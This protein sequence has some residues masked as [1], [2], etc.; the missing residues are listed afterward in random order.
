MLVERVEVGCAGV[1][2]HRA[3]LERAEV[4]IH[5]R[6]G[7][8]ELA[9]CGGK[10]GLVLAVTLGQALVGLLDRAAGQLVVIEHQAALTLQPVFNCWTGRCQTCQQ[11]VNLDQ[12]P[13]HLHRQDE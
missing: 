13:L 4:A 6:L 11:P 10:L 5:R 3:V 9:L 7:L 8:R 12:L 2:G 1:L